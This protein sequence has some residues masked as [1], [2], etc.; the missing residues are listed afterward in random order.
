M[1]RPASELTAALARL[2]VLTE[3]PDVE[4]V[5]ELQRRVDAGALRVLVVGEAKRGKSSVLNALLHRAV[6]PTGVVPLTAIV[7]TVAYGRPERVDVSYRDGRS[8]R[9]PLDEL[10]ALVT[11]AGNPGNRRQVSEVTVR[12]DHA[13]LAG[14]LELVDTPGTGSVYEHNT[15]AARA[16]LDRADVAL[17]VVTADPPVSA[18]ERAWLHEVRESA[19]RVL[20]ILNK[21]DRLDVGELT[22]TVRFT[23]AVLT[24]EFGHDVPLWPVSARTA[25]EP[26]EQWRAFETAFRHYLAG[27][28]H[29]DLRASV[30][31]R[32][33]RLC[34]RIAERAEATMAALAM[35]EQDL[36][37]RLSLFQAERDAVDG[38]RFAASA[39]VQATV[40][41]LLERTSEAA[42]A[43]T[44]EVQPALMVSVE[45]AVWGI[46]G[47]PAKIERA[48]LDAA[49]DVVRSRVGAW[50]QDWAGHLDS[51]IIGL[52]QQLEVQLGR[53]V[54]AVRSAASRLFDIDLAPLS[55]DVRLAQSDRF[56]FLLTPEVG[57]TEAL[58]AAV[59]GR[60]PGGW[61][62][63]RVQ[64]YVRQ[65]ATDLLDRHAGR[66]RADFSARL[67]QTRGSLLR[68][69]DVQY[70][71]GVGGIIRAIE[72]A[73]RIHR[74]TTARVDSERQAAREADAAAKQLEEDFAVIRGHGAG[75]GADS[76]SWAG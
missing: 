40:Q 48:A 36:R 45:S 27:R 58:A 75:A 74:T 66:A 16:A 76:R 28:M 11:E 51:E 37:N 41:A 44:A 49:G 31:E 20:C 46:D 33:A 6:L 71:A 62:R 67:V 50:R 19:V 26:G 65:R 10:A 5:A 17:F 1:T 64:R 43:M 69:L 72:R 60:L 52:T 13:L 57:Q 30:A 9:V 3:G 29:D 68:Q 4:A 22:E 8:D 18:S 42:Q 25:T 12:L 23:R 32:G 70:D 38:A 39:L 73:D 47:P 21:S 24:A 55:V 7:T 53:H 35:S 34:R 14:G 63:R 15:D 54:D 56:S 59:R 61:G 2:A